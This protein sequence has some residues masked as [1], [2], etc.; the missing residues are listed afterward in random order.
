MNP[1]RI[2]KK[3]ANPMA[4][5]SHHLAG[6]VEKDSRVL[7][8]EI[9]LRRNLRAG[10]WETYVPGIRTLA[11]SFGVS[12]ATMVKA[13]ER[14]RSDG[15]ISNKGAR[16]RFIIHR[17]VIL[18]N[19]GKEP[20]LR[21]L[22]FLAPKSGRNEPARGTSRVLL[23]L[24]EILASKG[25]SI[26]FHLDDF[27]NGKRRQK[28]WDELVELEKPQAVVAMLGTPALA[29]WARDA[30]MPMFFCGGALED[31]PVPITAISSSQMI[32]EVLDHL[33]A[34]G[35]HRIT[36]PM[37][38]RNPQYV[39]RAKTLISNKLIQA[40]HEFI[41]ELN[42]PMSEGNHRKDFCLCLDRAFAVKKPTAIICPDWREYLAAC[43][44][45]KNKGLVVP[46]DVSLISLSSDHAADWLDPEPS[47]FIY[48]LDKLAATLADW[49]EDMS[50]YTNFQLRQRVNAQWVKGETIAPPRD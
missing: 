14:V 25:W 45:L 18:K 23:H 26:R 41:T 34:L 40:G 8:A 27:A 43:S 38:Q 1:K 2:R 48:P 21:T 32:E 49:L 42:V 36:I 24:W 16:R 44:Y 11:T 29:A 9:A 5:L 20:F 6:P 15:W 46:D 39:K 17:D 50:T 19:K 28:Q 13:V 47:R 10:S 7:Q 22:L 4:N 3:R 33:I 31:F 37:C 35:H 12:P 30:K